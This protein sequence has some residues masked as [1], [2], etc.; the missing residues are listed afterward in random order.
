VVSATQETGAAITYTGAWTQ[1]NLSGAF[2]GKVKH[3]S[4]SGRRA[5]FTFEGTSIAWVSTM[6]ANRGKAD[7]WLDG[8]KV[9]TIDLYQSSQNTR[10]IVWD[11]DGLAPGSHTLEIRVLG[12]KRTAATGT[13]VDIDAFVA[14]K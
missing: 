1:A 2:G 13:R 6:A 14:L 8:T 5:T 12:T 10:K 4:A 3:A 7:V 9:A 11:R